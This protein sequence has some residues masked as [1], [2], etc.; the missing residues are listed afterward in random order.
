MLRPQVCYLQCSGHLT[1]SFLWELCRREAR[2]F[3]PAPVGGAVAKREE[4]LWAGAGP[5]YP[6]DDIRYDALLLGSTQE[7]E[8]LLEGAELSLEGG[9]R[10]PRDEAGD[11]AGGDLSVSK[12]FGGFLGGRQ[13][14]RKLVGAAARPL[15]KRYGGFIGVRK[16]ARKWNS[17]KRVNQ[18]LRQY[19]GLRGRRGGRVPMATPRRSG[20][21]L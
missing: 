2:Q 14:Y 16:S 1:S 10:T 8:E 13:G 9:V 18:L 19:L 21:R 20:P 17:Q 11:E 5:R 12:R 3:P 15:Q 4:E 6:D 7:E